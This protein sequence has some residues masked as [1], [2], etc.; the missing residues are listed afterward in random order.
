M[1]PR[2]LTTASLLALVLLFGC[3]SPLMRPQSPE[4]ENLEYLAASEND[5]EDGV[6]LIGDG[7][8]PLGLTYLKIENVGLVSGLHN[9]GGDSGPSSL[10]NAL[11]SEMQS[12]DVRNPEKLLESPAVSL[13]VVRGY[14]PP[15]VEKGDTFD[16]EVVVPPKSKTTSLRHGFL[17]KSRLREMRVLENAIHSGHVAGLVQGPVVVDSI[18]GGP[19]NEMR[20]ARGRILGGG[21]S[22]IA[23]PLG[24]AIRGDSTVKRAAM[25]GAAINSRFHRSDAGGQSGVAKPKR[26]NYIELT[27]HPRYKNNISRY[28]RVIGSIAL[29]ES[30]GERVLR[31]ES[32]ERR[33]VEPTTSARAALQLEAIGEDA[34]H[35]LLKGLASPQPEVRFYS[36]E[37]L[38]YLDRE[39]AAEVLGWAAANLS[40]FRWHAL[41]ALAA[42]DHVAAYEALNELL[43]VP[44]A[45]TRYG[46]FR[47]LRTRNAADPLV[48]GESLGGSFAYHVISSDAPPMIHLSKVQRA[49]I[50]LFGQHQKI[51]PPAFL[52][53]GKDIMIKG[54]DDGRIRLVR[55]GIGDQEDQQE[56]CD[57]AVDPLVRAIVRLGGK[58]TDVIQALQEARQGGY[59][60]SRV[61]VNALANPDR[62]YHR[63]EQDGEGDPDE[64]QIRVASPV[65]ELYADRLESDEEEKT[66]P[67]QD[68]REE[69]P[70]DAGEDGESDRSFLGRMTD[71]FAK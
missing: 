25:I 45:E 2:L 18:F 59:L 10:R 67:P 33:L 54:T 58:Y 40:A 66:A 12:Y 35:I 49:E 9:T 13:V 60:E 20:E 30:P 68:R 4:S 47:A 38:A 19:D 64:P 1:M 52:Y 70:A 63:Q 7:T 22:Q 44:S 42:M 23:R 15:G 46:A 14:L 51:V 24:L 65:P 62:T 69:V 5:H 37:A 3:N 32:L 56:V 26:D 41:T 36:A 28:V 27:V 21:Q 11:I 55:F 43:H 31:I 17:L 8:V 6:K 71:W 16:V 50:V 39:E 34:A 61:V 29:G 48:R 53:A 57:A